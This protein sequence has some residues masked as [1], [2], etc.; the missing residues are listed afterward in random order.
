MSLVIKHG[1]LLRRVVY[2]AAALFCL[3]GVVVLANQVLRHL[4]AYQ[5]SQGALLRQYSTAN[6]ER[7]RLQLEE[8]RLHSTLLTGLELNPDGG[9][10]DES[11]RRFLQHWSQLMTRGIRT[12]TQR[13]R[14]WSEVGIAP[15]QEPRLT[16]VDGALHLTSHFDLGRTCV[17]GERLVLET[18]TELQPLRLA[19]P[20]SGFVMERV[21]HMAL[22]LGAES[23]QFFDLVFHGEQAEYR[24]SSLVFVPSQG[25][26]PGQALVRDGSFQ[27]TLIDAESG[28]RVVYHSEQLLQGGLQHYLH[29]NASELTLMLGI[30]LALLAVLGFLLHTIELSERLHQLSTRDFLTGLYNR[31]AALELAGVERARAL[32]TGRGFCVVQLDLD[33]F[34]RVNDSFGHDAGDAVLQCFAERLREVVRESDLLARMGGE[35]FLMLLPETDL[36][37]ARTV[38]ERLRRAL[39]TTAVSYGQ[40]RITF[41]CSM[42][43]TEWRGA[44][45]DLPAMLIRAD[46]LLYQ[47][48][49]QGRDRCVDDLNVA[50][51]RAVYA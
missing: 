38:A 4:E 36:Q 35:E 17:G 26:E 1:K 28:L 34:K 9:C 47:A 40:Q 14:G 29:S 2:V 30:I 44:D 16:V 19:Q 21:Q 32:R 45:D 7:L 49:H 25:A 48:K 18:R 50:G 24:P 41:T 31:R 51:P 15:P 5:D 12:S 13:L 20:M 3:G 46:Q 11:A 23:T 39:H 10:L 22:Q 33:H 8:H 43:L 6:F 42:G 27:M 37:G